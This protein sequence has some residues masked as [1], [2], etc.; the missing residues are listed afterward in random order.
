MSNPIT[1]AQKNNS[2]DD[3]E[4]QQAE[5]TKL[6][7]NEHLG[8]TKPTKYADQ[9]DT[10]WEN[11]FGVIRVMHIARVI[12]EYEVPEY[13][14]YFGTITEDDKPRFI[15]DLLDKGLET[16]MFKEILVEAQEEEEFY[17]RLQEAINHIPDEY[18]EQVL[19]TMFDGSIP[20]ELLE[21][22]GVSQPTDLENLSED[23]I[24]DLAQSAVYRYR[25]NG[26]NLGS[27][28]R[29][30][31]SNNSKPMTKEELSNLLD[32]T[33]DIQSKI[34]EIPVN[35]FNPLLDNSQNP[36]SQ[37]R[38]DGFRNSATSLSQL[39]G[40]KQKNLLNQTRPTPDLTAATSSPS[41]TT[42][43]SSVVSP[44]SPLPTR[45]SVPQSLNI[46][47][48]KA[49]TRSLLSQKRQN[50][51]NRLISKPQ[52]FPNSTSTSAS[53]SPVVTANPTVTPTPQVNLPRIP[54]PLNPNF[55]PAMAPRT[56]RPANSSQPVPKQDI[57]KDYRPS[58]GQG[59]FPNRPGSV[60][61][62]PINKF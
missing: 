30:G 33:K 10:I 53:T 7:L 39:L 26:L 16:Y 6:K 25:Q 54:T 42:N 1:T 19:Q 43:L 46:S 35:G 52:V 5:L 18:V 44:V 2:I 9:S 31:F 59:Q 14:D 50:S 11:L 38:E 4:I 62:S 3:Y 12:R 37:A 55:R 32:S 23:Q 13:L 27:G 34:E 56:L 60:P 47:G 41:L 51:D 57:A 58:A 48:A 24:K 29:R 22:M 20:P 40:Q 45:P 36:L 28:E 21:Q 61:G 8:L 17:N 49:I 15:A